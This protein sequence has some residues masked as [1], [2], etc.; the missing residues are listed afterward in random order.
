MKGSTDELSWI[1]KEK[2]VPTQSIN[3]NVLLPN[4]IK[5]H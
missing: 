2:L 3:V 1:Q 5:W 4:G